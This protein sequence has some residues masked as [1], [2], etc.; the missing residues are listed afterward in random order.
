M[1]QEFSTRGRARV[2][3]S[4]ALLIV[5]VDDHPMAFSPRRKGHAA[6]PPSEVRAGA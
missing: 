1:M 2:L 3:C 6:L 4:A 5:P